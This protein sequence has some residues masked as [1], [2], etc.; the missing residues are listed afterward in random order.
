[1]AIDDDRRR[2]AGQRRE[3]I[4]A[5][6]SRELNEKDPLSSARRLDGMI[7][8]GP[9]PMIVSGD[10]DGLVSAA[11]LA[12]SAPGWDAVALIVKSGKVWLHPAV[13]DDLD[14]STCFGVDV[15]SSY[16]PNV[17]NHVA[18]WG[19][20]R[21]SS[22]AQA[23]EAAAA[24]DD[25]LRARA[26]T[27]LMATPSLWAGI[28]G[29]YP[30]DPKRPTSAT[31]RYPLG[32]AQVLLAMLEVVDRSP[33]MFDREYLPWLVA[34][35][36]G[37]LK[38]IRDYPHNV[39]MWWSALAASVGP[40]SISEQVYQTAAQQRPTEFVDIVNKLRAEGHLVE[41][42]PASHLDDKWNLRSQ[43][44]T[45][46]APV[47]RWITSLSGWPDPFR[48]GAEN[49]HKWVQR[50]LSKHGK[51]ATSGL[52]SG[53]TETE[54]V[55]RFKAHLRASLGA[56]H[57]NFAFFDQ[58]QRLN[59]VAPWDGAVAPEVP[60]LPAALLP[61]MTLFADESVVAEPPA[62]DVVI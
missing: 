15:F 30:N 34:N 21:P 51:L 19:G 45:D 60:E 47:V 7:D 14:L 41:G 9:R 23:A 44:L 11:M 42:S 49:L 62:E 8:A 1:V 48:G 6:L 50:P 25:V 38:T 56:V 40:A 27:T 33:K 52:P 37:G 35:C 53:S 58:S 28:E 32:T 59:W 17:S 36:D 26:Q 29:S 54:R 55:E 24:H 4:I 31:Y 12:R 57:T 61:D 22:S 46:I 2:T 16:V 20:K 43:D 13:A 5:T 39:P 10:I 3:N 18:L